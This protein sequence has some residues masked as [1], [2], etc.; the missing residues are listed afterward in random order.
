MTN[1]LPKNV[2]F[3]LVGDPV[4]APKPNPGQIVFRK[5]VVSLFK[6]AGSQMAFLAFLLALF[7]LAL[8]V[9]LGALAINRTSILL[10]LGLP[11]FVVF[12]LL[13]YKYDDY[14]NDIYVLTDE[15]II[16]VERKPLALSRVTQET[17]LDRVQNVTSQQKGLWANLLDYGDVVIQTAAAD[18]GI[19]FSTVRHPQQVQR[20]IF[21]KMDQRRR[22]QEE[23]ALGQRQRELIEGLKMYDEMLQERNVGRI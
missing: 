15:K 11:L 1:R 17:S 16:D 13:L 7:V 6:R 23:R 22:R 18:R 21:Q 4:A 9:P 2:Q 3:V 10:A 20:L 5:H 14:R 19:T 8:Y 12:L